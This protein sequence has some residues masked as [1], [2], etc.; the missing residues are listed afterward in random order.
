MERP[1]F[2][3]YMESQGPSRSI[4]QLRGPKKSGVDCRIRS[5]EVHNFS[6]DRGFE[7][8]GMGLPAQAG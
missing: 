2:R 8:N 3:S 7:C 1:C 6:Y 4:V 5:A